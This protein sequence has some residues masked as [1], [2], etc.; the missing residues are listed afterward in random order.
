MN[1]VSVNATSRR[2]M[3]FLASSAALTMFAR[4]CGLAFSSIQNRSMLRLS[5][6]AYSLRDLL[7]DP[8]SNWDLFRFVNYCR[9]LGVGGAELT[10][11]YFPKEIST[12][13]LLELKQHCH[14]QGVSISGGAIRNDF[15]TADPQRL[16]N[17][18][19]HTKKWID[20][21]AI[22][23]APVIRIFAGEQPKEVA[24][25]KTIDQC[26]SACKEVAAYAKTKGLFLGLENHG[27]VTAKASG[28]LEIYNR[29]S[30]PNLGINF[31]SGNFRSTDDPYG[32]LSSIAPKAV[33]A[34]IKLSIAPSGRSQ[35]TDLEQVIRILRTANYSGWVALEYEEKESPLDAIPGWIERLKPLMG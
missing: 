32:E 13:Y 30:H 12:E 18:I 2:Q 5:L 4:P 23:G 25:E 31:D 34:Q 24:W 1:A 10:S 20:L 9:E 16:A 14:R 27:G 6:A 35:P 28:L 33:N 29:V 22:L 17:D 11:Y 7:S 15:C 21:Y 3:L 8:K 26:A 19:E